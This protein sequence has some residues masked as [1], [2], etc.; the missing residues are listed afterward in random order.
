MK[1]EL[2][3]R[4]LSSIILAPIAIFFIIKGSFLFNFFIFICFLITV[5]EWHMMS[6]KKRYNTFGFLFLIISF[7]SIYKLRTNLPGEY[8]WLLGITI[9]CVATDIGGYIFGKIFKG[10]KLTKFSPN[11][12]YAGMIGG[13]FL[14]IIGINIFLQNPYF[15][16]DVELSRQ[17]FIL[18]LLISTV[19]QIGDIVVSYFKRLSKIKDTGKIIPG[20]GGLLDRVDGMIFAF[21]FSYLVLSLNTH[22]P[23]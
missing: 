20:H 17:I 2:T 5:Y 1:K 22:Y 10:P 12:T 9:V 13:Y 15:I 19:S 23:F 11:K 16:G 14:S 6:K 21:P 8:A 3:K 18:V 7:Y 4:I